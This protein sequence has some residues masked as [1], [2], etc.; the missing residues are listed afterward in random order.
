MKDEKGVI[1]VIS[2]GRSLRPISNLYNLDRLIWL[3]RLGQLPVVR[4]LLAAGSSRDSLTL[5][6]MAVSRRAKFRQYFF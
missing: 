3:K 1:E 4:L 2:S 5:N 6:L